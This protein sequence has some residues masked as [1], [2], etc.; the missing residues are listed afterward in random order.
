MILASVVIVV[1]GLYLVRRRKTLVT[2]MA[3]ACALSLVFVCLPGRQADAPAL[4][5]A[6]VREL[7]A[8]E[9]TPYVW[10]GENRF[11][12]DCSGLVR[13]ALINAN[14]RLG[15]QTLNPRLVR[16]ALYLWWNDCTAQ[17]LRDGHL[18]LTTRVQ[19]VAAINVVAA[20][21]LASGDLAVTASGVHVL[22]HL[23]DGE[24]IEA[25]PGEMK[26][27]RVRTP[28]KNTWFQTPVHIL[29]WAELQP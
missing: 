11:G 9:G 19:S 13:K 26:V 7:L 23:G 2:L 10:G 15:L 22:A 5:Q 17:A 8:Y 25:D 18:G 28:A 4:R 24:W 29:R 27:I 6:Y 14:L 12:I 16:R 21:T 1:W 20:D 3:A